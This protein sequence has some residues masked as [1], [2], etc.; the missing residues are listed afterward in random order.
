[1]DNQPIWSPD[2]QQIVFSADRRALPFLHIKDINE[3]GS[4]TALVAPSGYRQFPNDWAQT[5]E[6]QFIIYEDGGEETGRDLMLLPMFGERQPRPF[7]R[8]PFN[9]WGARFSPDGRWVAYQS[10]ETGRDEIFVR[11]VQ[12][13]G[14][15]WQISTA[16]GASPR[17]RRDG[18]ELFYLARD[19]HLMAVPIRMGATIEVGTPASLFAVEAGVFCDVTADG[20]RFLVKT[21]SGIPPLPITV[22]LNWT[23]DMKH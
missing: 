11:A 17:W 5:P 13:S 21:I 4:G 23:A 18:K 15:K 7:L 8:T 9:E 22:V 19:H 2:G 20:Q 10:N 16:G 6:G 14:R 12:A 3:E 1:M